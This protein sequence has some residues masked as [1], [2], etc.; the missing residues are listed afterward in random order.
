MNQI[1]VADA[2]VAFEPWLE[3]T[4]AELAAIEDEMPL[5]TAETDLLDAYVTVMDRPATEL[6]ERRI[7]RARRRVLA[8][9]RDLAN[10]TAASNE[11]PEVGA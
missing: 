11:L 6:D 4:A 9:R 10:R 5:I 3:P 7:R 2:A 8:A 1:T